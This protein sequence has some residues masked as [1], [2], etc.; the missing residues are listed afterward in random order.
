MGVF[1]IFVWKLS[2]D[3]TSSSLSVLYL[4]F[5]TILHSID[6]WWVLQRTESS[7]VHA[8]VPCTATKVAYEILMK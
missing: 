3:T 5:L 1:S 4:M 6:K 8:L 2:L 7:A